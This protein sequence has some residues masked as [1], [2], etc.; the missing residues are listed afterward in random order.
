[1]DKSLYLSFNKKN[2]YNGRIRK[3]YKISKPKDVIMLG[4]QIF[5]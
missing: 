4:L 1:M 5:E 2:N 3:G